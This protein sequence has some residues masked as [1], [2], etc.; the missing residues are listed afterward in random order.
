[1]DFRWENSVFFFF[2]EIETFR[3]SF[4]TF[5]TAR[6]GQK[7]DVPHLKCKKF[8]EIEKNELKKSLNWTATKNV[9]WHTETDQNEICSNSGGL[10]AI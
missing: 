1:M 6:N 5:L 8:K 3:Q 7:K 2:I 9:V 4:L 10:A